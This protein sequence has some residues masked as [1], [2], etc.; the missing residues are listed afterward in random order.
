MRCGAR[1]VYTP[2]ALV[3]VHVLQAPLWVSGSQLP[4]LGCGGAGQFPTDVHRWVNTVT[5][6][7]SLAPQPPLPGMCWRCLTR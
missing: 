6:L 1:D 4:V 5:A 7:W 2:N 3:S